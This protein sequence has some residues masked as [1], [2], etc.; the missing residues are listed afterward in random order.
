VVE[1]ID[2]NEQEFGM[3]KLTEIFKENFH[4]EARQLIELI[5][6]KVQEFAGSQPQFDDLTLLVVKVT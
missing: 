4:L 5:E 6:N 3:E 2:N 1:A